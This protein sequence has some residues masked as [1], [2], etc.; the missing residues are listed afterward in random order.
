MGI[1]IYCVLYELREEGEI[2]EA[3]LVNVFSSEEK[4]LKEVKNLIKQT[5]KKYK[6]NYSQRN[7]NQIILYDYAEEMGEG[8]YTITITIQKMELQ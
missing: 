4:A 2:T 8:E 7:E 3:N 6:I 5:K 1:N